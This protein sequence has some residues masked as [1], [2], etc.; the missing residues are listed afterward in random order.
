MRMPRSIATQTGSFKGLRPSSFSSGHQI[1]VGLALVCCSDSQTTVSARPIGFFSRLMDEL[2]EM[3]KLKEG[4][5]SYSAPAPTKA[6]LENAFSFVS[7]LKDRDVRPTKVVPSVIGG[8]AFSFGF[9][10]REVFIEFDNDGHVLCGLLKEGS[11]PAI[12]EIPN[13]TQDWAVLLNQVV[14]H[15]NG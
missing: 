11:E 5:D 3:Y 14:N 4:W 2:L 12:V 1:P 13:A 8:I 9:G 15:L 10:S 6:A 7:F